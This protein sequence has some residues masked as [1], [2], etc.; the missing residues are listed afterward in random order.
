MSKK[1]NVKNYIVTFDDDSIPQTR[2][3]EMLGVAKTKVTDAVTAMEEAFDLDTIDNLHYQ[4][5]GCACVKLTADAA[6]KLRK[7]KGVLEVVEDFEVQAIGDIPSDVLTEPTNGT[8]T[9][10]DPEPDANPSFDVEQDEALAWEEDIIAQELDELINETMDTEG[11]TAIAPSSPPLPQPQVQP[12]A[13]SIAA[14]DIILWNIRKVRAHIAWRKGLYGAGIRVAVL[15]TGIARHND[16]IIYGGASF[17][18]GTTSFHDGNG[19]GTHCAGII[20]AR[21]NRRGIVG[22]APLCRLY[23][24]KVLK[25]SGRGMFSWI[26]SGMA[27]ALRRRM[28]VVSMS[29]GAPRAPIYALERMVYLLNRAG[30]TV[31]A[32]AGNSGNSRL[33]PYVNTPANCPGV[34]AVGAVDYKCKIAPFSSR[35]GKWNPVSLVAPG[36]RIIS[37]FP[38]N[39]YRSLSGTSMACPHVTGGAA[40]VKRRFPTA[41]PAWIKYRL[42]KSAKD[43][44]VPGYDSTYGAGLLDCYRAL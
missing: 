43:L 1:S 37:T 5:L 12:A 27:W 24:V 14:K 32:A 10:Q 35:G 21:I 29:L 42:M 38:H 34:I 15:D 36:V 26:L 13:P 3:A 39:S 28:H 17:V 19:H 2:V 4:E 23:A 20:G 16:L 30:I 41:S 9:Y 33:F 44:G 25:D 6:E 22:V 7:K 40:L 11:A 8:E 31:V 18:P